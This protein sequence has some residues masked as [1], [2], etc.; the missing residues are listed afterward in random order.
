MKT[1]TI[2]PNDNGGYYIEVKGST[3]YAFGS[4]ARRMDGTVGLT[5]DGTYL[6]ASQ[7]REE[8]EAVI[9]EA[10]ASKQVKVITIGQPAPDLTAEIDDTLD[11]IGI[12]VRSLEDPDKQARVLRLLQ[13]LQDTLELLED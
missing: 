11:T 7:D 8:V 5:W 10:I 1:L 6:P 2:T 12:Q 4:V 13:A 9:N 3:V